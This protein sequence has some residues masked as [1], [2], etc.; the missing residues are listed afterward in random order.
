MVRGVRG[1]RSVSPMTNLPLDHSHLTP[2]LALRSE[3]RQWQQTHH[4]C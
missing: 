3:I 4:E 1:G 2:N